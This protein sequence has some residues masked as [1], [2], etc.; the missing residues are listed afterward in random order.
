MASHLCAV[1]SGIGSAA[2]MPREGWTRC[3]GEREPHA[4]VAH[5]RMQLLEQLASLVVQESV[6]WWDH[7][8]FRQ[9][10]LDMLPGGVE[11]FWLD[12]NFKNQ[13]GV[14]TW[15][16]HKSRHC[17]YVDAKCPKALRKHAIFA[18]Q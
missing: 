16:V 12:D 18:G 8:H 6:R 17:F 4:P 7:R 5:R 14:L 9:C 2:S 1:G 3:R 11:S 13:L 10:C 15:C